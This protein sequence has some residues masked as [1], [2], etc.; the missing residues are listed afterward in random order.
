MMKI[1]L[2]SILTGVLLV[3]L[4][5]GTV[6][7]IKKNRHAP[8]VKQGPLVPASGLPQVLK[9]RGPAAAPVKLVEFSDFE[10]PSCRA[11]QADIQGLFKNYPG[12]IQLTFK[13][14]P[15]TSHKWS[16]YA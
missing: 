12:K 8:V 7:F 16:L 3:L 5:V 13:H 4:L 1:N 11:V 6:F 10:C 2:R 9:V 14:F 15:L